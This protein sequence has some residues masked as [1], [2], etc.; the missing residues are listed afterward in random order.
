MGTQ[1]SLNHM[2]S[3]ELRDQD[4]VLRSSKSLPGNVMGCGHLSHLANLASERDNERLVVDLEDI[5]TLICDAHYIAHPNEGVAF[6]KGVGLYER[7]AILYYLAS[8]LFGAETNQL[9]AS[10]G[11]IADPE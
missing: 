7:R 1:T 5:R 11:K 2:T 4:S 8:A 10:F 9:L 6:S 3:E